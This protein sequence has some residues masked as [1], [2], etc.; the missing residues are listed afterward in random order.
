MSG[1]RDDRQPVSR[2]QGTGA[3]AG[4]AGPG[5]L[6]STRELFAYLTQPDTQSAT[7]SIYVH[8]MAVTDWDNP[9]FEAFID[10]RQACY[11]ICQ[12][13]PGAMGPTL[14]SFGDPATAADFAER[15]RGRVLGFEAIDSVLI[16][17][18]STHC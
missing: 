17:A 16:T 18:L 15:H 4:P 6:C 5:V 14:A 9:A 11:V 10:A 2:S 13:L 8:D 12:P 7:A 3:G 1:L